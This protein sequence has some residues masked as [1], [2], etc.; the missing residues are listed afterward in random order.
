MPEFKRNPPEFY[1]KTFAASSIHYAVAFLVRVTPVHP[2][3]ARP[4]RLRPTEPFQSRRP[5]RIPLKWER[6]LDT[7]QAPAP[8]RQVRPP[9]AASSLSIT[10]A[11]DRLARHYD[12]PPETIEIT[13][14]G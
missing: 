11:K 14:R 5:E 13:I 12:V 4:P 7:S 1:R 2:S 6:M 3:V 10:E 8:M 9:A